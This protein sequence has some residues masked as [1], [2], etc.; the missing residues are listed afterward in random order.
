MFKYADSSSPQTTIPSQVGTLTSWLCCSQGSGLLWERSPPPPSLAF[1]GPKRGAGSAQT[2]FWDWNSYWYH[3]MV[4]TRKPRIGAN[5]PHP[6][7]KPEPWTTMWYFQHIN[8]LIMWY[9]WAFFCCF[10]ISLF[11][12]CCPR[13]PITSI[14]SYLSFQGQQKCQLPKNPS[15]D[16]HKTRNCVFL[17]IVSLSQF[18]PLEWYLI[19]SCSISFVNLK[20]PVRL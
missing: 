12:I 7:M 15:L 17:F 18:K 10:H 9:N 8:Y 4:L 14:M 13:P 16:F 1:T 19:P 3:F 20:L 6:C 11:L 5:P 2:P